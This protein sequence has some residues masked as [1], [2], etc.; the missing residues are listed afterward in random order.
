MNYSFPWVNQSLTGDFLLPG[1]KNQAQQGIRAFEPLCWDP[2][3]TSTWWHQHRQPSGAWTSLGLVSF[4]L[5]LQVPCQESYSV[6]SSP[7]EV[8]CILYFHC[9]VF[10]IFPPFCMSFSATSGSTKE[11]LLVN[12]PQ[13][14]FFKLWIFSSMDVGN[15][16]VL[17]LK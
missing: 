10:C 2:Q 4:R 1:E 11:E 7:R 15:F 3:S 6:C 14:W 13:L 5:T 8:H 17:L 12:H 16:L 9:I